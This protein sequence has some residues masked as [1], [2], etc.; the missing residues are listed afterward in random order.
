MKRYAWLLM[1]A[2]LW[3]GVAHAELKVAGI[4]GDHMVLQRQESVPIWGTAN[5]GDVVT[6]EFAGQQKAATSN[7]AGQWKVQLDAMKA[8]SKGRPLTVSDQKTRVTLDDVLVGDVWLCSGQSNMDYEF[9]GGR[10]GK[11]NLL[12]AFDAEADYPTIRH[13][14]VAE[15]SAISPQSNPAK[16]A[17]WQVCSPETVKSFSAV[18]YFFGRMV[19][20]E[21]GVP[22]GLITSAVGG[23]KIDAWAPAQELAKVPG[24]ETAVG[25][26]LERA[27]DVAAGTFTMEGAMDEWT[28]KYDPGLPWKSPTYDASG[29]KTMPVPTRWGSAKDK[30]LATFKGLVW[31]RRTVTLPADFVGKDLV[32][33]V[34]QIDDRDTTFFNGERIGSG[35]SFNIP[36]RYTVPAQ[37]VKAGSNVIAVRVWNGW[38]DGGIWGEAKDVSVYPKGQPEQ[39]ITLAGDWR[40]KE[41]LPAGQGWP[42]PVRMGIKSRENMATGLYNGMIAPVVPYAIRGAIWYQGESNGN[43]GRSYMLKTRALVEGW[44]SA[45]GQG[46]FPFYYVQLANFQDPGT[47]PEGG[48]GWAKIRMAQLKAL[49]IK[50]T[51]MAV[52]IELA[53]AENPKDVHPENKKDVGERLALWALAKDYGRKVEYSGP[54][55]KSMT[56]KGSDAIIHFDHVG[57]GLMVATKVGIEPAKEVAGG[58]LKEFSISGADGQWH[59]ADAKIVG[60]TVVVS[61]K[62]VAK[63][64]AVRYAYTMNPAGANLYNKAGLPASPFT[65]DDHWHDPPKE[66]KSS[67]AAAV[68]T[69]APKATLSLAQMKQLKA[70]IYEV[71]KSHGLLLTRIAPGTFTMGSPADEVGRQPHET[72]RSITITRAF[73]MGIVEVTQAQYLNAMHPNHM[74][75]C[76]NKGPWGHTLPTIFKGGPWGVDRSAGINAGLASDHP[77]DMLTWVEATQYAA[78]LNKREAAA[79]RLPKGYVYRLP[80]EAEWE[81]ACRA[82][83]KGP[84]GTAGEIAEFFGFSP[85][86]FDG[87]VRAPYGR[88][89]P[90]AWGLYDM[91]GSLYEWVQ[92]WHGPYDKTQTTDP[93]GLSAGKEKIVRGGSYISYKEKD[94]GVE[95]TPA[96]RMRTIRSASRNHFPP[97]YSLPITGMRI[98]LAPALTPAKEAKQ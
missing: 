54:L 57:S 8:S 82:G 38:G 33:S 50:N 12:A 1:A 90:N 67:P 16:P 23:T 25:A 56:I 41:S 30:A 61:S 7:K 71:P 48:D 51:G 10:R 45:W 47:S 88:R 87:N 59:L 77:M 6:V 89:K 98:V 84:F 39:S 78:W 81:Y 28:A 42:A 91:H 19:H 76:Q 27:K 64:M 79:G 32:V 49:D 58:T 93:A 31:F 70:G 5:P 95:T 66:E 73:Y 11:R 40:Y 60:D 92:D 86:D 83:T 14:A 13:F 35:M 3:A 74:E 34:A 4:L 94:D 2:L 9:A 62:D 97:D 21:T 68:T 52:A 55:Y 26:V 43:E 18:G 96:Q 72:Q 22:V 69:E 65:T 24:C 44:R 53:D 29:W 15:K 80:T 37:L 20:K 75:F 17:S 63:P 85:S 36:R 46:E